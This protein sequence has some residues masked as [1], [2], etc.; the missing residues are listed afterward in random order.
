MD[1]YLFGPHL[2]TVLAGY[3]HGFPVVCAVDNA[4]LSNCDIVFVTVL[5]LSLG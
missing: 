5:V 4:S 1:E 3:L 2:D